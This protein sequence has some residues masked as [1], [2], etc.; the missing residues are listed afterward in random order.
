MKINIPINVMYSVPYKTGIIEIKAVIPEI[1][2]NAE[3]TLD[4]LIKNVIDKISNKTVNIAVIKGAK[5]A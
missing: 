1:I 4:F 2:L 5:L 3:L